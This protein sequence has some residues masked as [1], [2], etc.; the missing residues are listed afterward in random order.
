MLIYKIGYLL[1]TLLYHQ[2]FLAP[3][4][5][6]L[7]ILGRSGLLPPLRHP[8]R[9]GDISN[10]EGSG[11]ITSSAPVAVKYCLYARKSTEEEEQEAHLGEHLAE[12]FGL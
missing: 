10:N 4:V 9:Y 8:L 5:V 3:L 6:Y 7:R 12:L 2:G 1:M 11:R